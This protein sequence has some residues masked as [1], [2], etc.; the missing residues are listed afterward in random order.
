MASNGS[1]Q[2]RFATFPF[3]GGLSQKEDPFQITSGQLQAAN[4]VIFTTLKEA[5]TRFG[6]LQLSNAVTAP[7]FDQGIIETPNSGATEGRAIMA[8]NGELLR[9]IQNNLESWDAA[10][11]NWIAKSVLQSV[12]ATALPVVRN[13]FN[14]SA[15]DENINGSII[16]DVAEDSQ[17]GVYYQVSDAITNQ[18]V[19]PWS[20]LVSNG[21]GGTNPTLKPK[22]L[23]IGN[24]LVIL[25]I[26]TDNIALWMATINVSAPTMPP[27]YTQISS[28]SDSNY[29]FSSYFAQYDGTV[30]NLTV[31]GQ[32]MFITYIN[33]NQGLALLRFY[34][35]A[36][37]W[38]PVHTYAVGNVVSNG[39]GLYIVASQTGPSGSSGGPTGTGSGIVDGDIH[40]NYLAPQGT[41]NQASEA[42]VVSVG[43]DH[44][45]E[46]LTVTADSVNSLNISSGV[47]LSWFDESYI[48][49]VAGY[50]YNLTSNFAPVVVV[51]TGGFTALTMTAIST[52]SSQDAGQ[53]T[54]NDGRGVFL[55]WSQHSA[56]ALVP[57]AQPNL[58]QCEITGA[59]PAIS[60]PF[61]LLLGVSLAGKAFAE[62]SIAYTPIVYQSI[63]QTG[64]GIQGL[65]NTI[66][67]ATSY[68]DI[69]ARFL[70][71]ECSGLP[72]ANQFN[73]TVFSLPMLPEVST[74]PQTSGVGGPTLF[75][76][77]LLQT[78]LLTDL[79]VTLALPDPS[80]PTAPGPSLTAQYQ[81]QGVTR[82]SFN[83]YDPNFSYSRATLGGL[84]LVGGANPMEYDGR[85]ATEASF[86]LAPENISYTG[87]TPD[88]GWIT[89]GEIADGTYW[90]SFQWQWTNGV[91]AIEYSAPSIPI[92]VSIGPVFTPDSAPNPEWEPHAYA[93]LTLVD[94]AA[95]E[96]P[97]ADNF[98]TYLILT[99]GANPAVTSGWTIINS[100][101]ITIY[102]TSGSTGAAVLGPGG[103]GKASIKF[104]MPPLRL[105]SKGPSQTGL[106]ENRTPVI[107]MPYRT[108][109]STA[110]GDAGGSV[111]FQDIVSIQPASAT[112]SAVVNVPAYND[113]TGDVLHFR[114]GL[115]DD[116]ILGNIELDTTGGVVQNGPTNPL[117]AMTVNFSRVLAI[118]STQ[119]ANTPLFWYTKQCLP[120]ESVQWSPYF[121]TNIDQRG[122]ELIGIIAMDEHTMLFTE[123]RVWRVEG[124]GPDN[125]GGGPNG[126]QPAVLVTSDVGAIYPKSI[127]LAPTGVLFQSDKGWYQIDRNLAVTYF[128]AQVEG[129]VN[130]DII[131]STQQVSYTNQIRATLL[132]G[133][134]AVCFDYYQNQFSQHQNIQAVDSC[135]WNGNFTYLQGN[136]NVFTETPEAFSDN[137]Q[138]IP[139]QI[140]TPWIDF[141]GIN[142]WQRTWW[143]YILGHIQGT[144]TLRVDIAYDYNAAIQQTIYIPIVPGT[145][146]GVGPYGAGPYG[147]GQPLAQL[148]VQPSQQL[149]GAMQVTLTTMQSGNNIGEVMS[150]S[151]LSFEYGFSRTLRRP[152][153][154]STF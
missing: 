45:V 36:P 101:S 127:F 38:L 34:S 108:I 63:E 58:W 52:A 81:Q 62:S 79:P 124:S 104:Q 53:T 69:I 133:R 43:A 15:Q 5:R 138:F 114:D 17:G 111:Y 89:G 24:Y 107:L 93:G 32:M 21:F 134:S 41:I 67:I 90:Y 99:A 6:Y 113:T 82:F 110:E 51:N 13:Q 56:T 55:Y 137:G 46:Q 106:Y 126:F 78:D 95:V 40:W 135:I 50:N 132:N 66:F 10:N 120:G 30:N 100:D 61:I 118:D 149:A 125:T 146:Y 141:A 31:G 92:A 105:T 147:G 144:G 121:T 39:G 142:G 2:R 91:G 18:A 153:S 16:V 145:G 86:H 26:R 33:A 49:N 9:C 85:T 14:Q 22:V 3:S 57:A 83:L 44:G 130:G 88:V 60:T 71:G 19:V 148:R 68:G 87:F 112:V 94:S 152:G 59:T 131:T 109:G 140:T 150:F 37:S 143:V 80:S 28:N 25:Y 35:T 73:D 23:S 48:I 116:E 123:T 64:N 136:G 75:N 98:G 12:Y 97:I 65:Q 11:G 103:L 154:G 102:P 76:I 7:L 139:L 4:N 74:P 128:G 122:G 115:S 96:H 20:P 77:P 54:G 72:V 70:P 119:T 8:Y 42:I 29:K 117:G 84:L 47:I 151:G 1:L 129:L 27:V